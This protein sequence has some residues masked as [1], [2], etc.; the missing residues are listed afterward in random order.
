M[1]DYVQ[2]GP[3]GKFYPRAYLGN[4]QCSGTPSAG[5]ALPGYAYPAVAPA[6]SFPA[7]AFASAGVLLDHGDD[8]SIDGEEEWKPLTSRPREGPTQRLIYR[9]FSLQMQKEFGFTCKKIYLTMSDLKG[10]KDEVLMQ[11]MC[12]VPPL[13]FLCNN[14][15]KNRPDNVSAHAQDHSNAMMLLNNQSLIPKSEIDAEHGAALSKSLIALRKLIMEHLSDHYDDQ[16]GRLLACGRLVHPFFKRKFSGPQSLRKFLLSSKYRTIKFLL[17]TRAVLGQ[18]VLPKRNAVRAALAQQVMTKFGFKDLLPGAVGKKG[19]KGQAH[20][21]RCVLNDSISSWRNVYMRYIHDAEKMLNG[22]GEDL[23]VDDDED[24]DSDEDLGSDCDEDNDS[25]GLQSYSKKKKSSSKQKRKSTTS[26]RREVADDDS[27]DVSIN[28]PQKKKAPT[29]RVPGDAVGQAAHRETPALDETPYDLFPGNPKESINDLM[30]APM[31]GIKTPSANAHIYG[32]LNTPPS[33]LQVL[34]DQG[35]SYQTAMET[36]GFLSSHQKPGEYGNLDVNFPEEA[37]GDGQKQP[38]SPSMAPPNTGATKDKENATKKA[39]EPLPLSVATEKDNAT[40]EVASHFGSDTESELD[41]DIIPP[42]ATNSS[43]PDAASLLHQ[44]SGNDTGGGGNPPL[45]TLVQHANKQ[46]STAI[47]RVP[48]HKRT[49]PLSTD[50]RKAKKPKEA[51]VISNETDKENPVTPCDSNEPVVTETH[52]KAATANQ[53]VVVAVATEGQEAVPV[54]VRKDPEATSGVEVPEQEPAVDGVSIVKQPSIAPL[55]EDGSSIEVV[56]VRSSK[57]QDLGVRLSTHRGEGTRVKSVNRFSPGAKSKL[58]VGW[59]V[60]AIDG[61]AVEKESEANAVICDAGLT[62]LFSCVIPAGWK[63][64]QARVLEP[65]TDIPFY[66]CEKHQSPIDDWEAINKTYLLYYTVPGRFMCGTS[67]IGRPRKKDINGEF[68]LCDST[69]DANG[70]TV[71]PQPTRT[72]C[73]IS[74]DTYADAVTKNDDICFYSCRQCHFDFD[75]ED[76]PALV[77]AIVCQSCLQDVKDSTADTTS[78]GVAP[79]RDSRKRKSSFKVREQDD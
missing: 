22:G 10:V 54:A 42:P 2:C 78:D 17:K 55:K 45:L 6:G 76:S 35:Y 24:D 18:E 69:V 40:K 46:V 4:H 41:S 67:C 16:L 70:T 37:T 3:C 65:M 75:A 36:I 33:F 23:D 9:H 60:K 52:K 12:P 79:G 32:S 47:S 59:I 49:L 8:D 19:K 27:S 51:S 77:T 43:R 68:V 26:R 11:N 63:P 7:P 38:S 28:Y 44:P 31:G 64:A 29:R 58:Q 34:L 5:F 48:T 57:C 25:D 53:V 56:V 14:H 30:N 62:V 72:T 71:P 74:A 20:S 39:A 21:F 13:F 1:A 61:F 66:A 15:R 50:K 73:G